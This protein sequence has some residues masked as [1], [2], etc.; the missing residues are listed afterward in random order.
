MATRTERTEAIELLQKEFGSAHGIFL[1]DNHKIGV[2]KVTK[3]RADLRKKGVKFI[4]VKNTLAKI[5]CTKVGR[6]DLKPHFKGPTAVA[7]ANQEGTSPAKIL[8]D[9]QKENKELLSVKVAFVDGALFVGNDA[10][11]L[12]DLPSREVLLS[13]LLGVLQAPVAN[14]A[15][16]LNAILSKLVGTIEAVKEKKASE[17]Q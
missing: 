13:Q 9:F 3:L 2:A 10:L 6:D 14:L 17:Q 15:G 11:K 5:A 8:R 16:A 7:I 1:T 4:V 12:A